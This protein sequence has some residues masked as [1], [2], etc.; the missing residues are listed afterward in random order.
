MYPSSSSQHKLF[1]AVCTFIRRTGTWKEKEEKKK[2][3]FRGDVLL[4]ARDQLRYLR[5]LAVRH[6][7]P[8]TAKWRERVRIDSSLVISHRLSLTSGSLVFPAPSYSGPLKIITSHHQDQW[9]SMRVPW[10]VVGDWN[11]TDRETWKYISAQN[12]PTYLLFFWWLVLAGVVYV[13]FLAWPVK[14]I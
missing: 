13:R 6:D 9:F 7:W 14:V 5:Y 10:F 1:L 2:R 12:L 3:R 11:K 8:S 4:E